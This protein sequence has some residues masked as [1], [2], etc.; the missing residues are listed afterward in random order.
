MSYDDL[1]DTKKLNIIK[2]LE[3]KKQLKYWDLKHKDLFPDKQKHTIKF[4][5]VDLDKYCLNNR[6]YS[7]YIKKKDSLYGDYWD[8]VGKELKSPDIK[9]D[10]WYQRVAVQHQFKVGDLVRGNNNHPAWPKDQLELFGGIIIS[11]EG[12]TSDGGDWS[13]PF[14]QVL[15]PNGVLETVGQDW[16]ELY[17]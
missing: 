7:K 11:T 15:W 1:I 5:D 14:Y 16:I 12:P 4:G 13:V 3:G 2:Q 8:S 10:E 9:K 17:V 6:S